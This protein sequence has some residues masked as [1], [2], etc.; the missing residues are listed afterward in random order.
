MI[1]NPG[2]HQLS[3]VI[4]FE[5]LFL[6]GHPIGSGD[7]DNRKFV[8][9]D[10]HLCS[11][12]GTECIKLGLLNRQN[13]FLNPFH[14][15]ILIRTNHNRSRPLPSYKCEH[16][17][18]LGHVEIVLRLTGNLVRHLQR[19]CHIT[20]PVHLNNCHIPTVFTGKFVKHDKGH[21]RFG[22]RVI[23][24]QIQRD[25]ACPPRHPIPS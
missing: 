9:D 19:L 22:R 6:H 2:D 23:V 14:I 17:R 10:E 5:I 18:Q 11:G 1:S 25:L 12:H 3:Q 4:T 21:L 16:T 8:V 7:T 24:F 20:Q 13:Q 15:P